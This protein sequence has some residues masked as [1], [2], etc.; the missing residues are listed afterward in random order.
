MLPLM[1]DKITIKEANQFEMDCALVRRLRARQYRRYR[2]G[3]WWMKQA[4]APVVKT[5]VEEVK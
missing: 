4:K 1:K 3:S 2:G 5:T